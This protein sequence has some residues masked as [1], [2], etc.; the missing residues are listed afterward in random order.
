LLRLA[1]VLVISGPGIG[2]GGCRAE[3]PGV[4][5]QR[6][7]A[8]LL[9]W[10][11]PAAPAL[12]SPQ[13]VLWVSLAAQLRGPGDLYLDSAAGSLRLRDATGVQLE[14]PQLALRWT[15]QSL[16]R[17]LRIRR[18]VL[19]PFASYES[20]SAVATR[21]RLA[22]AQPLVARAGDWEVWASAASPALPGQRPRLLERSETWAW[23]PALRR[24]GRW[25]PLQGPLQLAAPGGLRWKG[26]TYAG[27]FRLQADAHGGWT[28]VEQVPL[29]RY[30]LGVVPLEIGAGAPPAALAAQAVLARTWAIANQRRFSVDGYHLCTDTQCQ[31]YGDPG[32]VA[33]ALRRAILASGGRVLAWQGQPIHAV[34]HA[35][36]GGVAAGFEE[37]WDG[38]PLPYLR[39]QLDGPPSGTRPLALPLD[40]A[41]VTVLLGRSSGFYGFEH[42]SFRWQR[43]LDA[44]AL[45]A[46]LGP[47]APDLGLPS[48]IAVLE[49]GASGRVTAL[50]I[51]GATR[52]VL[53]RDAIR[54]SIRQLPSTLFNVEA[55]GPGRWRFVGGGYGHG[56]GLSQ[57]GA[58]DLAARGWSMERI[59]QRYYP[60]TQLLPLTGLSR[61][62]P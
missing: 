15:R 17:P 49:R 50:E 9:H 40:Q 56:A 41:A 2:A 59:L 1:A 34:Y 57:A 47:G 30:L 23:Q 46:A 4:G 16:A 61:S 52:V 55:L 28:L 7:V 5:A 45:A 27:S 12:A 8:D 3:P 6:P 48:R 39:P 33:P 53:R 11:V 22:G 14:A 35:S 36:N 25:Q 10:P 58:I 18:L 29:E 24:A 32:V 13:P 26:G 51:R 54:R 21:W 20:A 62:E 19:G 31:V 60:G 44:N 38:A 42:P 37:S 43:V